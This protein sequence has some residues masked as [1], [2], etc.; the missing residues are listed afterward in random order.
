MENPL[1]PS[2]S[3]SPRLRP[4]LSDPARP[5]QLG[6]L[7]VEPHVLRFHGTCGKCGALAVSEPCTPR[8]CTAGPP[9]LGSRPLVID[10]RCPK[11]ENMST[12]TASVNSDPSIFQLQTT[13]GHSKASCLRGRKYPSRHHKPPT[14]FLSPH[15]IIISL[16]RSPETGTE[17]RTFSEPSLFDCCAPFDSR[18]LSPRLG[19]RQ[20]FLLAARAERGGASGCQRPQSTP[21]RRPEKRSEKRLAR[22]KRTE[23]ARSN[24]RRMTRRIERGNAWRNTR[25]NTRGNARKVWRKTPGQGCRVEADGRPA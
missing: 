20:H 2:P 4:A 9:R 23:Y 12:V 1:R 6:R 16:F 17:N 14:N 25:E 8:Q 18:V 11:R 3:P 5:S 15:R 19:S 22:G 24:D 21:N 10:L 13:I 7:G